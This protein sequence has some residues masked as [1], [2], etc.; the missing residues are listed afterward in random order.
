MKQ[1]RGIFC[2][3][4]LVTI[5]GG[6][7]GA[8]YEHIPTDRELTDRSDMVVIATVRD[9]VARQRTDGTIVTDYRFAVERTLKG[10]PP[11]KSN[12]EITVTEFG[13][14]LGDRVM[15][16]SDGATYA[17][18]ERVMAFLRRRADG[19]YFTTSMSLGKFEFTRTPH[20]ESALV[21]SSEELGAEPARLADRFERFV[22][23]GARG[24]A[25]Y[26]AKLTPMTTSVGALVNASQYCL[27]GGGLPVRWPGG[28]S[29]ATVTFQTSTFTSMPGVDTAGALS[30]GTAA[31]TNDP[32]AFINLTVGGTTASNAPTFDN[33]N[34]VYFGSTVSDNGF[35]DGTQAC[36][37]G[38]GTASHSY[39]GETFN[40]ISDADIMIR[41]SV[42][43][44]Q[45]DALMT[46]EL[47]HAI[48]IRH[49]NDIGA[50]SPT[51]NAIMSLPVNAS[52]GNSLQTWDKD[53]V[54]TVYGNGPACQ[55]PQVTSTSGG[56]EVAPGSTTTLG[57]SATGT[58]PLNYQWYEGSTGNTANPISGANSSTFNTP[59]ITSTKTYWVKVGNSCGATDSPTITVTVTSQTCTAPSIT[60][61]P[62]SQ[63]I[64]PNGTA[65]LTVGY[66]GTP[67]GLQWYE[68][69][70]GDTSKPVNGAN[71]QSF[72]AGPLTSSTTFWVRVTNNCGSAN[73]TAA[74]ITVLGACDLPSFTTQPQ[75]FTPAP[76]EPSLLFATATNAPT[77]QWYKGTAPDTATPVSGLAASNERFVTQ[78]FVDL[79]GRVPT[80]VEIANYASIAAGTSKQAAATA[81][82]NSTEYRN[83]L[84][85]SFYS[86]FLHRT[87]TA[88]EVSFWSPAFVAGLSDEQVEAQILGS[89]EYFTL[90][91]GTNGAWLNRV[92]LDVLGRVPSSSESTAFGTLLGSASRTTVA[93]SLLNSSEARTQRAGGY[94]TRLLRRS[95]VTSDIAALVGALA[96]GTSDETVIATLA[97]APEYSSFGTMLVVGP[98]TAQTKYWVR[99]TN[100]CGSANS[101]TAT[102]D[103]AGCAPPAILVQPQNVTAVIGKPVT[104]SILAAGATSYQ[105]YRGSP[106]DQSVPVQGANGATFTPAITGVGPNNYWV[107]VSNSCG[108]TN[109][110]AVTITTTCG[111]RELTINVPPAAV[112][113]GSYSVSWN[114]DAVYDVSY[115]LQEATKADF[116]DAV[117][118]ELP[119]G[120]TS[121]S[122]THVVTA[123]T[124]YYYRVAAA[125]F[126]GGGYTLNSAT[127]S[128]VVTAPPAATSPSLGLSTPC[129]SGDCRIT[130]T[131]S[132]TF[133]RKATG[134]RGPLNFTVT[135]DQTWISFSP[136]SGTIP[137]DGG[138]IATAT[139]NYTIDPSSLP[140]GSTEATINFAFTTGSG[141]VG[142]L[143]ATPVGNKSVP[144]SVSK[145]TPV[146]PQP[147][148]NNA[149]LNAMLIPAVAHADGANGSRFVSDVRITNTALQSIEYKLTF[150][151]SNTD[152]TLVGKTATISVDGGETK[153]LNDI[154]KDWYGSGVAG[155][156]G[157]GTLEIRPLNY[158]GKTGSVSVSFATAASS[159]TYN[160][161]SGGTFGQYIPA[162]P[163]AAFL[164]K[165]DVSKISLQQVAQSATYRTNI[166][167][168]EGSGQPVDFLVTL[169][170]DKG[171]NVAQRFYSL[172][173]FEQQQS[174][175]DSFFTG[176][177]I[178]VPNVTDGRVEIKVISD[179]GRVTAYASVLDNATSDPLLVF[180][181]DPSQITGKRFVVP[182][183]AELTT[184]FS[185][186]HTDMRIY[187]SSTS[188]IDVT[189]NYVPN[190]IAA[191][192]PKSLH[193]DAGE[194]KA[195]DNVLQTLWGITG[196]GGAVLAQTANDAP[197]VLTA[198]TYSRDDKG[199]TFGQ[200]IPGVTA[201]DSVGLGERSLQV[202]QLESSPAYRT[203]LGLVEVTGNPVTVD[204]AAFVPG[205][206]VAAHI[207]ITLQPG[208]FLQRGSIFPAMGLTGNVYNGRIAITVTGGT[209][210]VAA[211]G[212]VIDNR[213]SDP[214]YI[215][216]Q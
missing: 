5:A 148:D 187:N 119:K 173:P 57:V 183:V 56:G 189:L 114:G 213:T 154:V 150:T 136:S 61:N 17:R 95:G 76:N 52:L 134:V 49:A 11:E 118:F 89:A 191:P 126:C 117:S 87:P 53:A 110:G 7:Q 3:L 51:N 60:L 35:C 100:L 115:Q 153:A 38:Q 58:A 88:T 36:T 202:V 41:P 112:S 127:G 18:G 128:T 42:P 59:P 155:E 169:L 197:L 165:S 66:T 68:G 167:F 79:L 43:A 152:G 40:S 8:V 201:S 65:T 188:G 160:V 102:L 142:A 54:D 28:E 180:P 103:V 138:D 179:T 131:V 45:I 108:S 147:K 212:S 23:D 64:Q 192:A 55:A 194:V 96:A 157:L 39:K 16:V 176:A 25:S 19:T 15:F 90:A 193:L 29:G 12:G 74:T 156:P 4:A 67:G 198:R 99:A 101:A 63:S 158:S 106:P 174:R 72:T 113:G 84:V 92:F 214:T 93:L 143:D 109:S 149:P 120:T 10:A 166:G 44:N 182:G 124:R 159:R 85:S 151:P 204:V 31:W 6:A 195:L 82:L 139:V 146:T 47:G 75:S 215:P 171:N 123:D 86:T 69:Q 94:Y 13:G 133:D 34:V 132:G 9:A 170:D 27:Q 73:S 196:S 141:K 181:V 37:I 21:R 164:A 130:G 140:T 97:G 77:Y 178:P 107:R 205:S 144:V 168:A 185:N 129:T 2:I 163:L 200:F 22:S 48:G 1:L 30:R 172:K 78:L 190:D 137:D 145:T 162:I 177:G 122:F 161:T 81:L 104:I 116:S 62:L 208:Q 121:R 135:A 105:W 210:R 111:P 203:N 207:S 26:T 20:G 70:A 206:K 216:A 186:F 199:G 32:L 175:L 83:R 24:T 33:Q 209:G 46:H 184:P 125:P 98:I 91:G 80:S 71:G 211:Y 14:I 50:P